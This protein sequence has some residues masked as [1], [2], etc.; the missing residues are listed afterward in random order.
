MENRIY[1]RALEPDDYKTSV[2][3]RNDEEIQNM[4]GGHK[5]FVSEEKEK[6]WVN[7][8]IHDNTRLVLA[9]C[10]VSNDKYIGNIMLQEID[11]INRS[12]LVPILLGDKD[13]W[14]KG[15][16][17]EARMLMLNFAFNERG[18]ERIFAEI[19]ENNEA[20]I[21]SLLKCGYKKEGILRN[22]V[23]KNGKFN[24]MIIMSVLKSEFNEEYNKYLEIHK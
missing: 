16:A 1:L 18:L 11:W 8:A 22:S 12:A 2:H 20:S 17:T 21:K 4:V 15:Y 14:G 13:E 9:I 19:I 5:Y 23:F 10:L 24:N 6:E 3:W 7:N